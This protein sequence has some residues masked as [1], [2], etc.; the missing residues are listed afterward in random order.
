MVLLRLNGIIH[1]TKLQAATTFIMEQNLENTLEELQM[2][3]HLLSTQGIQHFLRLQA[4]KTERFIILQFQLIQNSIQELQANFQK[5]FMLVLQQNN[6]FS[7]NSYL[8]IFWS[9]LKN[10]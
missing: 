3:A 1:S 4:L 2:K 9:F 5:K 7:K 6:G 8:L 10:V